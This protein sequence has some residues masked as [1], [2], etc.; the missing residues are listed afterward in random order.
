MLERK[1]M[2]TTKKEVAMLGL[3][4][5]RFPKKEDGT[6]EIPVDAT[7][8]ADAKLIILSQD[9]LNSLVINTTSFVDGNG[10]INIT[11]SLYIKRDTGTYG[12]YTYN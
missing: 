9:L 12:K 5:M 6:I 2:G 11:K 1:L 7:A 10:T 3:G 4:C 8:V